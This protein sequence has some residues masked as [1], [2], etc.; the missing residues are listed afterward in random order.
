MKR[1]IYVALWG[2]I[3][4]GLTSWVATNPMAKRKIMADKGSSSITYS[5]K[6]PMHEWDAVNKDVTCAAMYDDDTQ[7]FESVAVVAKI[8]SFDSQNANRDS[9]AIEVLD[10]IKYPNVTFS[11]QDIQ[12]G[13]NGALT[14]KGNLV[15]HGVSKP[16]TV[17]ATQ[18]QANG[19]TVVDGAF[20]LKITD[21]KIER[22]SLMMVP[23]EDEL[24]MKF[25]IAFKL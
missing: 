22:P 23:V 7:K 25:S 6:H 8:A 4:L 16:V 9:H 11:S 20:T 14:I 3:V 10:G 1:V 12:T 24:R 13:A 2:L 15:F 5:M 17:Q 18:K 21:F 19:K